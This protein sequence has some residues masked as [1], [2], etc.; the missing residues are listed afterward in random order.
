M[1]ATAARTT[2]EAQRGRWTDQ[3]DEIAKLPG[4][5]MF[6]RSAVLSDNFM[7][8]TFDAGG[9]TTLANR[10][11]E[12]AIYHFTSLLE[13]EEPLKSLSGL[14][15]SNHQPFTFTSGA[16]LNANNRAF[17]S[18]KDAYIINI[19]FGLTSM[20]LQTMCEDTKK[21]KDNMRNNDTYFDPS[22]YL[23]S[24]NNQYAKKCIDDITESVTSDD[25]WHDRDFLKYPEH[26]GR[27]VYY[28]FKLLNDEAFHEALMDAFDKARSDLALLWGSVFRAM[29]PTW[30]N[31][32]ADEGYIDTNLIPVAHRPVDV[33]A[34]IGKLVNCGIDNDRVIT[35][36]PFFIDPLEILDLGNISTMSTANE[37][38]ILNY[39]TDTQPLGAAAPPTSAK[40][41]LPS[42]FD[43]TSD[44]FPAYNALHPK[45]VNRQLSTIQTITFPDLPQPVDSGMVISEELCRYEVTA[46]MYVFQQYLLQVHSKLPLINRTHLF[47]RDY[48]VK[49]ADL[50]QFY[51]IQQ[52]VATSVIDGIKAP[53]AA[54]HKQS[55]MSRVA[56]TPACLPKGFLTFDSLHYLANVYI[57]P[58]SV[59]KSGINKLNDILREALQVKQWPEDSFVSMLD[60][61]KKCHMLITDFASITDQKALIPS[62]HSIL[63]TISNRIYDPFEMGQ[64]GIT[65]AHRA[66][67]ELQKGYTKLIESGENITWLK[68]ESLA[69]QH[70]MPARIYSSALPTESSIPLAYPGAYA[71]QGFQAHAMYELVPRDAGAGSRSGGVAISQPYMTPVQRGGR[72]DSG[73]RRAR[74]SWKGKGKGGKGGKGA[75][76]KGKGGRIG[77]KGGKGDSRGG[78]GGR[79]DDKK[80]HRTALATSDERADPKTYLQN[81]DVTCYKCGG[82]GHF[83]NHCPSVRAEGAD[84]EDSPRKKAKTASAAST[85]ETLEEDN[86]PW[87]NRVGFD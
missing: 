62:M 59:L 81:P 58:E 13:S 34:L 63:T 16:A 6:T 50:D 61:I 76:R 23:N 86:T 48:N 51:L 40:T 12:K 79:G 68:I 41:L 28:G 30:L 11:V 71:P 75:N 55:L 80:E 35:H 14:D 15:M 26:T 20:A 82:I 32:F 4:L 73:S 49:P 29:P 42:L 2:F 25:Q 43:S 57:G 53:W 74:G 46:K 19:E 54:Q 1:A 64:D 52:A 18:P 77:R 24:Y 9:Y 69:Q 33:E 44:T 39:S 8:L 47:H 22:P 67:E 70:L 36:K 72:P 27:Q 60:P 10:M 83:A 31:A 5:S 21:F 38:K 37:R 7:D 17:G 87:Y 85:E 65:T 3:A 45:E 84:D 56:V 78:R 66:R